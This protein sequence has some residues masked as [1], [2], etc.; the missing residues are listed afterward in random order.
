MQL[1][2]RLFARARDLAGSESVTVELPE[3]ASIADLKSALQSQHV[4]LAPIVPHLLVA[5]GTDY[6]DDSTKLDASADVS[7]FPPVSGG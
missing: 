7:C 3:E 6:A 4:G 1:S 5:V 2:V